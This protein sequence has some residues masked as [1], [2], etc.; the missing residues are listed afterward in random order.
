M[1]RELDAHHLHAQAQAEIGYLAFSG[2]LRRADL[3]FNPA[4]A[5]AA[6]HDDAVQP[7]QTALPIV[8]FLFKQLGIDKLDD[9]F[10]IVRPGSMRQ[11]FAH[12]DVRILQLDVLADYADDDLVLHG[13]RAVD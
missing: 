13:S 8:A 10:A 2:E 5:E 4:I 12:R 11:G 1:P 3:A 6:G 9:W 7:L